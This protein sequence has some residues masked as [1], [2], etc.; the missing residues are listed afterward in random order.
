[1]KCNNPGCN[2]RGWQ[3][4]ESTYVATLKK[5]LQQELNA[6]IVGAS[7]GIDLDMLTQMRNGATAASIVEVLDE[8][9]IAIDDV[10]VD[11][12]D[13]DK[14]ADAATT[15]SEDDMSP[16]TA[17]IPPAV[18]FESLSQVVDELLVDIDSS[19]TSLPSA[20]GEIGA[21]EA[22][23]AEAFGSTATFE[24]CL[25]NADAIGREAGIDVER[26]FND[27]GIDRFQNARAAS[28]I[29]NV[30]LRRQQDQDTPSV[31]PDFNEPMRKKWSELW[32]AHPNPSTGA[33]M[34]TWYLDVN[35]RYE[36]WRNERIQAAV[37]DG[38]TAPPL[39]KVGYTHAKQWA[40]SMKAAALQ[41]LRDGAIDE[42]TQMIS[43]A[44]SS[45]INSTD[46]VQNTE[47]FTSTGIGNAVIGNQLNVS[48]PVPAAAD[49]PTLANPTSQQ[50]IH[51]ELHRKHSTSSS[52]AKK[53]K[54]RKREPT[55]VP[56][57]LQERRDRAA[58]RM[59]DLGR[60]QANRQGDKRRCQVC[61]QLWSEPMGETPHVQLAAAK[62]NE[63][64][65]TFC[66]FADDPAIYTQHLE[67]KRRKN[68]LKARQ[69]R[70]RK[71]ARNNSSGNTK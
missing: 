64:I 66:P 13:I 7:D 25:N 61:F 41:P 19:T 35:A 46:G 9:T 34:R 24:G 38:T 26:H 3:T 70:A 58:A 63:P 17:N 53:V 21:Q 37:T 54:K 14:S 16:L 56:P 62:K 27:T 20:A 43:N 31:S 52:K 60:V 33:A 68:T 1:M 49:A 44:V 30:G 15:I 18:D 10:I 5:H 69:K 2:G 67:E 50:T 45:F 12:D 36:R 32:V 4:Y 55:P 48:L 29:R 42:E 39:H 6:I 57:E 11:D 71:L 22:D 59:S 8:T 28:S 40:D 47:Q 23:V 51:N 65:S